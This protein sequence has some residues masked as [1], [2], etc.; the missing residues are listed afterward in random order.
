MRFIVAVILLGWLL[1]AIAGCENEPTEL[2]DVAPTP[3]TSPTASLSPNPTVE[4]AVEPTPS[5]I[6][7]TV[8][9]PVEFTPSGDE[10]GAD[11][12]RQ[13]MAEFQNLNP[14]I[15]V[16]YEPK[17][18]EGPAGLLTYLRA[19]SAV[20][21]T[22]VPDLIV[23]PAAGLDEAA[24]TGLLFPLEGLLEEGLREDLYPFATRDTRVEGE[25]L[26]VPLAVQVEH[27]VTRAGRRLPVPIPLDL[28]DLSVPNAPTWLF[29]GQGVEEGE[30]SNAL[31][32]QLLAIEG[33]LPGPGA[34]PPAE[35]LVALLAAFQAAEEN[36]T[37]SRQVL[38]IDETEAIISRL[39]QGQVDL[40]ETDSRSYL[41]EQQEGTPVRFAPLPTLTGMQTAVVDGFLIGLTTD[42]E[43]RQA[44][45]AQYLSW[46]L[47]PPQ[48]AA[49]SRTSNWLPA[50]R[51]VLAEVLD[52]EE[53]TVYLNERLQNGWLRPSGAVW[54][55]FAQAVQEQFRTVMLGQTTPAEAVEALQQIYPSE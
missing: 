38:S 18:L 43:R 39:Q 5:T 9:A 27:G 6:R 1:L 40:V 50:R 36:G 20:A 33:A 32:L 4:V 12:L 48:L 24:Q 14:A 53:Y 22:I 46:L 3:A 29:A 8:W 54:G 30:M 28:N 41:A 42:D 10:E 47:D 21:P 51:S 37:I 19:A 11:L 26:A 7:L 45:A 34:L 49:W 16:V 17:P 44:A 15:Q 31:L 55:G 23:I 13:Q 25:W 35:E 52:D 2:P